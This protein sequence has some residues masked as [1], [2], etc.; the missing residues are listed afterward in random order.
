V[1]CEKRGG[2]LDE[3]VRDFNIKDDFTLDILKSKKI[4]FDKKVDLKTEIQKRKVQINRYEAYNKEYR[5]AV[6]GLEVQ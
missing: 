4:E 6:Y 2:R 1:F 5:A 3:V